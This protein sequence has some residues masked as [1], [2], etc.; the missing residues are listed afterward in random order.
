MTDYD[1]LYFKNYLWE[2]LKI[3]YNTDSSFDF[4]KI[5]STAVPK[6]LK[7][8][9]LSP[10][11]A[12]QIKQYA[13]QIIIDTRSPNEIIGSLNK[14]ITKNYIYSKSKK[15]FNKITPLVESMIY[16]DIDKVKELIKNGA[17]VNEP[18][19]I[20]YSKRKPIDIASYLNKYR[21]LFTLILINAGAEYKESQVLF[22]TIIKNDIPLVEELIQKYDC[23]VNQ[24]DDTGCEYGSYIDTPLTT[25]CRQ[26]NPE[27]IKKLIEL[28]AETKSYK[29]DIA[30]KVAAQNK[31]TEAIN[32]LLEAGV[33]DNI[34]EAL[35]TA[36]SWGNTQ[37]VN[38]L[39]DAGADING[40]K[41]DY[42][43]LMYAIHENQME[44]AKTL[45]KR[46]ADVTLKTPKGNTVSDLLSALPDKTPLH[47][48]VEKM[49]QA[50]IK[51]LPSNGNSR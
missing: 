13:R 30:L 36:A 41:N 21:S 50:K 45:I 47:H 29:A 25:A 32:A 4:K 38:I 17:D 31:G 22:N 10:E 46:G 28:G 19:E 49:I 1:L 33:N 16:G 14:D 37:T 24:V 48:E 27:M 43:P 5:V 20:N 44:T 18:V 12:N 23:D 26:N 2:E 34:C 8:N 15:E 11:K 51:A 9:N 40:T 7:R 6:Y 35:K 39:L 3:K 42:T